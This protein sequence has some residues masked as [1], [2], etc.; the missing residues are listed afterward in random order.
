MADSFDTI[1]DVEL[2]TENKNEDFCVDTQEKISTKIE[3]I[4]SVPFAFNGDKECEIKK[5]PSAIDV[6]QHYSGDFDSSNQPDLLSFTNEEEEEQEKHSDE[7]NTD[8]D[9]VEEQDII[10]QSHLIDLDDGQDQQS[11]ATIQTSNILDSVTGDVDC[12]SET[13]SNISSKEPDAFPSVPEYPEDVQH[14]NLD[15]VSSNTDVL[16]DSKMPFQDIASANAD[17]LETNSRLTGSSSLPDQSDECESLDEKQDPFASIPAPKIDNLASEDGPV[18]MPKATTISAPTKAPRTTVNV[19]GCIAA[20]LKQMNPRVYD[21]LMW[22]EPKLTAPVM[23]VILGTL[24]AFGRCS[25]FSV[26]GYGL[27]LFMAGIFTI[28][29]GRTLVAKVH[30]G[31]GSH[32]FAHI[33]EGELMLSEEAAAEYAQAAV[34]RL[35]KVGT[36]LRDWVLVKEY[37]TSLKFGL[38]LYALAWIGSWFNGLTVFTLVVAAAFTLPKAYDVNS[39]QVDTYLDLFEAKITDVYKQLVAKIPYLSKQKTQ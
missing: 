32:P 35:N 29:I 6:G 24:I 33:L 17:S 12:N 34:R 30:T 13:V 7:D 27:L 3:D 22:T 19:S 9:V 5:D 28:R 37:F 21:L 10:G 25:V 2:K 23:A 14:G 36:T 38:V 8:E 16:E 4:S 39:S 31:D 1:K 15:S 20:G 26:V 11:L 18:K